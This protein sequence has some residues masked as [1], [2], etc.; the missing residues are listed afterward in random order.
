MGVRSSEVGEKDGGENVEMKEKSSCGE[1]VRRDK[2]PNQLS[3]EFRE[4]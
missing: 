2:P 4:C 1:L 3:K